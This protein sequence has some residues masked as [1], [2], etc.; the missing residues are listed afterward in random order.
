MAILDSD[1]NDAIATL[2]QNPGD[3]GQAQRVFELA[4]EDPEGAHHARERV[5]PAPAALPLDLV[6][7]AFRRHN[8][9]MPYTPEVVA[10]PASLPEL[11]STMQTAATSWQ[12]MKAIGDGYGF[13]NTGSTKGY[14]FPLVSKLTRV[15]PF[16]PGELKAGVDAGH[17]LRFEGGATIDI[18]TQALW[19]RGKAVFNQPGYERLTYV[20]TMSSGGH[21][22]GTWCGP[23]SD[24]AVALHLVTLDAQGK[25]TQFQVEK[26][27]GISDPTAFK[28]Q[29]PEVELIQDDDK[30]FDAC[31]VAMGCLGI[32]YSATI[33][34]RDKYN[35]SEQ[36]T[37][38]RWSE[39]KA[40]LPT[41]LAEQGP[42]KRLHSIEVWINPYLIDGEV[43]GVLGERT[44]TNAAPHG[45]R[46]LVIEY[47]GPEFLYRL[48]AWWVEHF[49][50]AVP[51]LI[52]AA[53]SATQSGVVVMEAP[54]GLNFGATN[55]APVTAASCG[56]PTDGIADVV[57]QLLAWFQQRADQTESY[58][59]SPLGLRFV[60]SAN[61][62]MSPSFGRDTCMIEAPVLL[63]TPRARETLDAYHDFLAP[64]GGRPHWG[65]VNDM[66]PDRLAQLY[67]RLQ[68]FLDCFQALNPKGFF[69]NDFTEQLHLRRR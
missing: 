68:D 10:Q 26:P 12:P 69:D 31:T 4:R 16:A 24:H 21:G 63:G 57:D 34:V 17:L 58:I 9:S 53:L 61:A 37:K 55:L 18:V 50:K 38:L 35:I 8:L 41:L 40:R 52:N 51:G 7:Q 32:I 60:H 45:E 14:L 64:F 13:A 22:S 1:H 42:G 65:Q 54:K 11:V 39:I 48:I 19:A 6:M 47:G 33:K 15:L 28:A 30:L 36:R 44:E 59:T 49:P 2:I 43:W 25:V 27:P 20:G 67:P 29:H 23:L 66:P 56:V 3:S 62:L 5:M 46:A